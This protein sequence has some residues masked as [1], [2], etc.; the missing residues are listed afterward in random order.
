MFN[1]TK[2]CSTKVNL[3]ELHIARQLNRVR[4]GLIVN[5]NYK[6]SKSLEKA[7]EIYRADRFKNYE[8]VKDVMCRICGIG[9]KWI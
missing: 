1:S 8:V 6:Y 3:T 2:H 9:N 4:D 5:I 7:N